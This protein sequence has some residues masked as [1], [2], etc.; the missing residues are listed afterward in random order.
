[1][2]K[3][4]LRSLPSSRMVYLF[5]QNPLSKTIS[6]FFGESLIEILFYHQF[7]HHPC[8]GLLLAGKAILKSI[9]PSFHLIFC[10]RKDK[11]YPLEL[12]PVS[13]FRSSGDLPKFVPRYTVGAFYLNSGKEICLFLLSSSTFKFLGILSFRFRRVSIFHLFPCG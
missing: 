3:Y 4:P 11:V 2:E 5:R 7:F 10:D 13:S 12:L 6:N 9:S 1:V 8:Y